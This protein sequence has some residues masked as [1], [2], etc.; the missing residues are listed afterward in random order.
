[1]T[2]SRAQMGSQ[3]KGNKMKKPVQKK[4]IGG[5]LGALAAGDIKGAIP[6]VLP[7][8]LMDRERKKK[9][10]RAASEGP[11]G[12]SATTGVTGMKAGG[13]VT[14]GDGA[15]MKGHTKGKMR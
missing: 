10:D 13:K 11:S 5:A 2:I 4:A 1:M 8:M 14:R 12:P 3:L 7:M 15:C 6:G 9:R